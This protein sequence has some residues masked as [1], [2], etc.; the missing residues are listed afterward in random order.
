MKE[1][2]ATWAKD[3]VTGAVVG[4]AVVTMFGSTVTPGA[5]V[6]GAGVVACIMVIVAWIEIK[7]YLEVYSSFTYRWVILHIL[8]CVYYQFMLFHTCSFT[9][10]SM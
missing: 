3:S 6:V 10:R 1:A 8:S 5:T 7:L 4:A 9:L 2:S